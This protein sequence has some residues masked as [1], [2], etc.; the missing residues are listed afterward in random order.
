MADEGSVFVDG[1]DTDAETSLDES[2][3][4][5]EKEVTQE[6]DQKEGSEKEA[7]SKQSES[8]DKDSQE[9]LT[10]KGTKLDKNPLSAAHQLL[11]NEKAKVRRYEDILTNPQMFSK[12]AKDAGF[13]KKEIEKAEKE[14]DQLDFKPENLQNVE[15]VA[16]ALNKLSKTNKAYADEITQLKS[17]I[18]GISE[19]SRIN[20]VANN[21]TKDI[22]LVRQ[23]YDELNPKKPNF[24][25]ELEKEIG[26]MFDELDL[27]RRS[28]QYRGKVSLSRLSDRI[29]KAAGYGKKTG[30]QEA[31]T[32]IREKGRGKIVTSKGVD[33]QED[34]SKMTPAQVIAKRIKNIK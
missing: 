22:S 28:G 14:I 5:G 13:S 15:D 18:S 2:N 30:S 8:K 20:A 17:G 9:K 24:N 29:M 25:K 7:L 32:T 19:V 34:E 23:K 11:A 33:V 3:E 21:I 26:D 27:D 4:E 31:Q 10:D 12:Y 6:S 16:E 1:I